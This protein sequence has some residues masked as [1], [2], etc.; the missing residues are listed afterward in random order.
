MA[1]TGP[2]GNLSASASTTGKILTDQTW[3]KVK[4]LI[5]IALPRYECNTL[6]LTNPQATSNKLKLNQD[7][8]IISAPGTNSCHE[9][10]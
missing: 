4:I 1:P 7:I 2:K 3:I 5:V 8:N 9:V 10:K 6:K